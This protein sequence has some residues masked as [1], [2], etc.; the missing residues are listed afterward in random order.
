MTLAAEPGWSWIGR[1][2]IDAMWTS[3]H[4]T[5]ANFAAADD[6]AHSW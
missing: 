5:V 1:C 4:S 2:Q 3:L 6:W